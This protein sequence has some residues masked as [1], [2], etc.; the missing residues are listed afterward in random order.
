MYPLFSFFF[1]LAF[2]N[3]YKDTVILLLIEYAPNSSKVTNFN[4]NTD[5]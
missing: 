1:F 2:Y 5:F 3:I 4:V